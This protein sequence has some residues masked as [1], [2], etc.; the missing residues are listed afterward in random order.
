MNRVIIFDSRVKRG[1]KKKSTIGHVNGAVRGPQQRL[2]YLST[3]K[4]FLSF[5]HKKRMESI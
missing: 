1:K 4:E 2:D 5:H 3:R